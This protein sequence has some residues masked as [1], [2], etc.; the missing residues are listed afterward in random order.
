MKR[1]RKAD[2]FVNSTCDSSR[3]NASFPT[4]FLENCVSVDH[5]LSSLVHRQSF[6][7]YWKNRGLLAA[8]LP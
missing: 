7:D 4:F 8:V 5:I 2:S 6:C 1:N 3:W